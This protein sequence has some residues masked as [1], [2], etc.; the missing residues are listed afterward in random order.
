M[1]LTQDSLGKFP[2]SIVWFGHYYLIVS[3]FTK[4]L[5]YLSFLLVNKCI[6]EG[7]WNSLK[8]INLGLNFCP[9]TNK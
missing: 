3:M 5:V 7:A 1:E 8:D 6:L 9:T 4:G 2:R